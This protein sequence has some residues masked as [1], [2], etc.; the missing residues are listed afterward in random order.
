MS[1]QSINPATGELLAE[2]GTWDASALEDALARADDA[3]RQW[4]ATPLAERTRIIANAGRLLREQVEPLARA[5]RSKKVPGPA[6]TSP[7]M[8]KPCFARNRCRPTPRTAI[9][10]ISR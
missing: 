6:I 2:F 8:R 3:A 7:S 4:R 5:P 10:A 1:F 9:S